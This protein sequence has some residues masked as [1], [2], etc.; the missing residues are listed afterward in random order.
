MI[1]L[2]SN[3]LRTTDRTNISDRAVDMCTQAAF[4]MGPSWAPTGPQLGPSWAPV[5]PQLGPSWAPVGPQLL[6]PSWAQGN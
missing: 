2:E 4:H 6:G 3:S 5:G 1:L